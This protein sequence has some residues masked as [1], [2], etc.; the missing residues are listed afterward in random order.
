MAD[1][2]TVR[3]DVPQARVVKDRLTINVT[4]GDWQHLHAADDGNTV[5]GRKTLVTTLRPR[6][7]TA[8]WRTSAAGDLARLRKADYDVAASA[9]WVESSLRFDGDVRLH[10]KGSLAATVTTLASWPRNQPF[11]L[12]WHVYNTG[13]ENFDQLQFGWGTPGAADRVS[14]RFWS[15]GQVDVYKGDTKV[16]DGSIGAPVKQQRQQDPGQETPVRQLA[17]QVAEAFLL[18][19][20]KRSL[21]VSSNQG[22]GFVHTFEDLDPQAPDPTI[23]PPGQVRWLV[24]EGQATVQLAPVRF[25]TSGVLVSRLF[26]LRHAPASGSAPTL[27]VRADLPGYGASASWSAELVEADGVTPFSANGVRRECRVRVTLTGDGTNTPFLYGV[28]AVF[29]RTTA[30]TANSPT[31][32]DTYLTRAEYTVPEEASG[33]E[34]S[35]T[36][37]AP[38]AVETAGATL[39]RRLGNRPMDARIAG[40]GD[41]TL[42]AGRTEGPEWTESVGDETRECV[43]RCRDGWKA[44]ELYR[45]QEPEP[46]DGILIET[47]LATFVKMAGFSDS[48]LSIEAVG[49]PLPTVTEA[50]QGDFALIPEVG[51]TAA[52]WIRRLWETYLRTYYMGFKPTATGVKFFLASPAALGTAASLTLYPTDALSVAAGNPAGTLGKWYRAYRETVLEPEANDLYVVG[53]DPRTEQPLR[54]GYA[55]EAS[56]DPTTAVALRPENWLGEPRRYGWVDPSITTE[57]AAAFALAVLRGRLTVARRMG[58]WECDLLLKGDG[59][60]VWRG[61]VVALSGIGRFRV[62]SFSGEFLVEN[63]ARTVR[64]FRYVGQYIG[65]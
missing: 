27:T 25:P 23:T 2:L 26:V 53:Y 6:P 59:S 31:T 20:G 3:T 32:L 54:V 57:A 62:E 55:D 46:L 47:A 35:L 4:G 15:S 36:V 30:N 48:D 8:T 50:A 58:E 1:V 16:G 65:A 24:P 11:W 9:S 64:P 10:S 12:S 7:Y 40:V 42:L 22:E 38:A 45:I 43:L 17:G 29:E 14:L 21:A 33:V 41:I 49:F 34:L 39:L 63:T 56:M 51:D 5:T 60:P 61:D 19:F 44:L 52:E 28:S 13:N 37:R 18:P